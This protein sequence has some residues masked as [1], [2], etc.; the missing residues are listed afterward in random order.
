MAMPLELLLVRHGES[1]ANVIHKN[2]N[3]Q[4]SQ[5]MVERN[6]ARPDSLH[7]LTARG[8]EQAKKAGEWNDQVMDETLAERNLESV[9]LRHG[10][11]PRKRK[12]APTRLL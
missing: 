5:E 4:F 8:I 2:K 12:E 9:A 7:P 1:E 3:G 6:N 11:V 10:K